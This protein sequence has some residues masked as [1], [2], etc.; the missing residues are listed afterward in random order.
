M[1]N[2]STASASQRPDAEK[3]KRPDAVK[4]LFM[5]L[6]DEDNVDRTRQVDDRTH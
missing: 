1:L 5:R 4:T 3:Q 6:I 2:P